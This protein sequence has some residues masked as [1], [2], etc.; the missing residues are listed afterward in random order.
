M[1]QKSP[2]SKKNMYGEGLMCAGAV[3]IQWSDVVTLAKRWDR[4][5]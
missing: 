1:M 3:D 4:T 5:T 2:M